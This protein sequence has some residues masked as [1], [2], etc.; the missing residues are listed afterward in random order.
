[1]GDRTVDLID[2]GF[3][4]AI[5]LAPLRDS[6]LIVRSL[7]TWRHVLCASP[8]YLEK[9]GV[10]QHLSELTSHNCV[11]HAL[12][13]YENE[14]RFINQSGTPASVRIS[15]NLLTNSAETLLIVALHGCGILLAPRFLVAEE[16][17]ARRLV[18]I[19]PE[20]QSIE[21]AMNAI[22]AHRHRLSTKIRS[23]VDLL[24]HH[25]AEHQRLIDPDF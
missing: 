16:L 6:S 11:R 15:G 4:I 19:L 14:W 23:F 18:P 7:A 12:Y 9:H 1:M 13:P 8:A 17:V 24:A 21:F 5:Q 2:E 10:P 3:D 22:Y 25:R 20:Y